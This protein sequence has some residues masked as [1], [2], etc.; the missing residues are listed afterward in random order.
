MT[1]HALLQLFHD[2]YM[3]TNLSPNTYRG[4]LVNINNH[5]L[6]YHA[7]LDPDLLTYADI[8]HLVAE[9]HRKGLSNTSI[10]YVLA[11]Y[12]KALNFGIRRAYC[13]RNIILSYDKP[14]KEPYFAETYS[15]EDY[16]TLLDAESESAFYP[17]ILLACVCGLRRGEAA[18]IKL[19]DIS[20]DQIRI[21]RTVSYDHGLTI[22]PCKNRRQ[23]IVLIDSAVYQKL[24]RYHASRPPNPDG[25]LIRNRDGSTTNPNSI[26]R[27]FHEL[28]SR[29]GLPRIRFH[30]VRHTYATIMMEHD[31]HPKTVQQILGHS[32]IKVTL[33]LYSHANV[34]QQNAAL[35]VLKKIKK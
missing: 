33:D 12:R 22:T 29:I 20:P 11:T 28:S 14:R 9:L 2:H 32:S 4:Y 24:M 16:L 6:P 7:D 27:Y 1:V 19:E 15:E 8:D 5:I 25:Y 31:V 21:R 23:R 17:A 10:N 18:G 26:T 35:T 3:K 30:D 34:N 13:T